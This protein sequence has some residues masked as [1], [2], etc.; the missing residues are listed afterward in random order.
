MLLSVDY[1]LM[2]DAL[3]W[4]QMANGRPDFKVYDKPFETGFK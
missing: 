2:R 4:A 1:V 3:H